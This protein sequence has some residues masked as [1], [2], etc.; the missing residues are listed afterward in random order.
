MLYLE[1]K[2]KPLFVPLKTKY[3]NDFASGE[4]NEELRAYGPRWNER[5]CTVGRPVTLSHG[6]GK[7]K[8]LKGT[9]ARFKKQHGSTFGSTYKIA[10]LDVF[11]TLDIYIACILIADIKQE[12]A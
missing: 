10:I 5:T 3:Y 12:E 6:Y 4:K 1:I 8:R 2:V 11:G 7:K 9:I